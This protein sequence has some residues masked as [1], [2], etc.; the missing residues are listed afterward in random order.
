MKNHSNLYETLLG[1]RK[2]FRLLAQFQEIV[3]SIIYRIQDKSIFAN[4]SDNIYAI[5]WYS[6]LPEL[7]RKAENIYSEN[8]TKIK[9]YRGDTQWGWDFLPGYCLEYIIGND[10]ISNSKY[11]VRLSVIQISD[12]GSFVYDE[13]NEYDGDWHDIS[14]FMPAENSQSLFIIKAIFYTEEKPRYGEKIEVESD[15]GYSPEQKQIELFVRSSK[16][17]DCII[18]NIDESKD[19]KVL[20][21]RFRIEDFSSLENID[22]AIKEFNDYVKDKTPFSLFN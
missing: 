19:E 17:K 10:N 18:Y 16:D 8:D 7:S 6:G 5:P 15:Y 2:S 21:K 13:E 22:S 14:K 9:I 3:N 1:V 11:K 20:I 12:D 4:A